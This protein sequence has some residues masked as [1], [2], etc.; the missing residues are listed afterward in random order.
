MRGN[1]KKDLLAVVVGLEDVADDSAVAP[2]G[3]RRRLQDETKQPLVVLVGRTLDHAGQRELR[4]DRGHQ[5]RHEWEKPKEE[6]LRSSH[7]ESSDLSLRV[8]EPEK[9]K[10]FS[11]LYFSSKEAWLPAVPT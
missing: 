1:R 5:Q 11:I 2:P 6:K 3:R 8:D 10:L 9:Q 4:R 7:P